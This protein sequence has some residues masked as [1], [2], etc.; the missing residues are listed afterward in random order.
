MGS[1]HLVECSD[2]LAGFEFVNIFADC[3]YGTSDI[4]ARVFGGISPVS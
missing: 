4:V 2:P 1:I 3:S